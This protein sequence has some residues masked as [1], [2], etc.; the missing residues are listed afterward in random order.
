[1]D[2][3]VANTDALLATGLLGV[4][5][6]GVWSLGWRRG[7]RSRAAELQLPESKLD[8]AALALLG[9]LLAFS[10]SLAL[11]KYE[12]RRERLVA[13]A[14]SIGDFYTCASLLPEPA[15]SKLQGVIRDYTRLRL[16][17]AA[18]GWGPELEHALPRFEQMHRSM[19]DLVGDA[20]AQGTPIAV[21][22]TDTLNNL[23]SNHAARLAAVRDRL[24]GSI[25]L[26]L[27]LSATMTAGLVG[28]QQ[29]ASPRPS[30]AGTA[31]FITIVLMTIYV[32]LDLNQPAQGLIRL[33]QE[34][35]ER[36]LNSMTS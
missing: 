30:L 11:A 36:L 12:R 10:F 8:D 21:P 18:G 15:R 7:R 3:V 16:E 19:T 24:P 33:S 6:V 20:L 31:T 26:L 2:A 5:M 9:L 34:P 28:R 23:T 14:N 22:L 17:V 35:M 1:M 27:F 4:A 29:G 13:D 25:V 32:T